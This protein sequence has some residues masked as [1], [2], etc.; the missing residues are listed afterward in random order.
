M[1]QRCVVARL[2]CLYPVFA[3]ILFFAG[4]KGLWWHQQQNHKIEYSEAASVAAASTNQLALIPYNPNFLTTSLT[5]AALGIVSPPPT[6]DDPFDSIKNG[7]LDSLKKSV[8][9]RDTFR[10]SNCTL[11]M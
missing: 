10:S 1:V 5:G 2:Y 7:N 3:L 9:V 8:Q 6:V 11:L 4:E